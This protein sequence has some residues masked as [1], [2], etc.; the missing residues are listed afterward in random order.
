MPRVQAAVDRTG[1]GT[2]L[3]RAG[4]DDARADEAHG[5]CGPADA[6]RPERTALRSGGHLGCAAPVRMLLL[7]GTAW[8]GGQV[9]TTALA[10]GH[11]VTCLARGVSGR[12][13]EGA[14]V[15]VADRTRP[16]AYDDVAGRTW[17][18]VLDVA[19][20]P[21]QVRGAVQA[22]AGRTRTWVFVSSVSAYADHRTPWQDEDAPLLRPLEGDVM[23]SLATY[24][25]AKVACEQAVVSGLGADRA[26][27]ARAGL[28]GGPGDLSDRS[29]Y[30]PLRFARPAADDGS[31]LVPADGLLTSV[32]DVRDL[33]AWL[34]TAG[35]GGLSGVFDVTGPAVPFADH[36]TTARQVAGHTGPVVRADGSWL[37]EQGVQQWA[38]QRS[39]PLW[40]TDPEWSGSGARD[41]SRARAAGLRTRPL[42]ETLTDT[43]AWELERAPTVRRAGLTDEDER[44]LL[45][46]LRSAA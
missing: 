29:G 44:T 31:V 21:G 41:S 11:E 27:V 10:C 26:L 16:G 30:W 7:G 4:E 2:R 20:Q 24:G 23:D 40:L 5:T 38:G 6:V 22:L 3:R 33:A 32:V 9:V 46:A 15:V 42:A 45:A 28:V 36:L 37:L 17:D 1:A 35:V 34:V 12:V 13:P 43:L 19:R 18:V 14:Q 8:L 39:L 25:E